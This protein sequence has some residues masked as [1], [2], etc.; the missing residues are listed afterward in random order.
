MKHLLGFDSYLNESTLSAQEYDHILDL[1]NKGGIKKMWPSEVDSLKSGGKDGAIF[2]HGIPDELTE[3]YDEAM[4]YLDSKH[5]DYTF[6]ETWSPSFGMLRYLD[7]PYTQEVFD[8]LESMFP[9]NKTVLPFVQKRD[10]GRCF[11][12]VMNPED[13][14]DII[15]YK[16]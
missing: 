1:Y 3:I 14:K 6:E 5:I 10:G 2:R 15:G 16:Q 4:Q 8:K 12:Y 11:V 7:L 13:Y 9:E